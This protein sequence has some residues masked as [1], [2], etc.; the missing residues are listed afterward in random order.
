MKTVCA[1]SLVAFLVAGCA[2]ATRINSVPPGARVF[3]DGQYLGRAPV[4]HE[5]S[6]PLWTAKPV[7]LKLDGYRDQ[8]GMIRKEEL[9]VGPLIGG[10]LVLVPFLWLT[11]YPDEY[12]FQLEP[13][14]SAA[15]R[16]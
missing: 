1:L 14:Q 11:G 4:T 8:T 3:V 13:D 5:D 2:S 9:Q 10:A 16:R 12:T 7:T 6:G 15:V